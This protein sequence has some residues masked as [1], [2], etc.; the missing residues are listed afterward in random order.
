MSDSNAYIDSVT[1]DGELFSRAR[2]FRT[3]EVEGSAYVRTIPAHAGIEAIDCERVLHYVRALPRPALIK[4]V[5]NQRLSAWLASRMPEAP[6]LVMLRCVAES[7][8]SIQ[9]RFWARDPWTVEPDQIE[10]ALRFV[11]KLYRRLFDGL[12]DRDYATISVAG[13][14]RHG[15]RVLVDACRRIDIDVDSLPGTLFDSANFD[16]M[17]DRRFSVMYL[18]RYRQLREEELLH[19]G[20]GM[21]LLLDEPCVSQV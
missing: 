5:A 14:A 13:L 7:A 1:T 20:D 16:K 10:S 17:K 6:V 18:Q 9:R 12:Q 15:D 8:W 2:I 3:G 4:D 11:L 21:R 19:A